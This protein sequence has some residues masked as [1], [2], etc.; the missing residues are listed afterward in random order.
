MTETFESLR[1]EF[2]D[3]CDANE[4][5]QMSAD[6]L[7]VEYMEALSEPQKDYLKSFIE[8]W[9]AATVGEGNKQ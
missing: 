7:Y 4:L 6:E 1:T 5:P 3:W 9:E 8:R 2:H